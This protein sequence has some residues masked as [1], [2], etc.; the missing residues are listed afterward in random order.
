[1]RLVE[2][3]W[4]MRRNNGTV[5]AAG[6]NVLIS[7][8]VGAQSTKPQLAPQGAYAGIGLDAPCEAAL[9]QEFDCHAV[10]GE[11]S[12]QG[13][14]GSIGDKSSTD[15]V[16]ALFCAKA[17]DTLRR[18][19]L[20][21]CRRTPDLV[22]GCAVIALVDTIMTGWNEACQK[23]KETGQYCNSEFPL[24]S[25]F[26]VSFKKASG[27]RPLTSSL[28]ITESFQDVEE[29]KDMPR[30]ELCSYCYGARLR[31]MQNSPYSA[32][33][34][35]YAEISEIRWQLTFTQ[36]CGINSPTDILSDPASI[37]YPDSE[38]CEAVQKYKVREGDTCD[39]VAQSQSVSSATLYYI[40]PRLINCMA[41]EPGLE[42]CLPDQCETT[43]TI[44]SKE[45]RCVAIASRH[46]TSWTDII[47]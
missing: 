5:W 42:L 47:E 46:G 17:L 20:A 10:V 28:A 32:Y 15:S 38:R 27:T 19:V 2:L 7:A 36:E 6:V 30:K 29:L 16:C 37:Q 4:K 41:P 26:A 44:Q 22:Q 9:Y 25:Q 13:H 18:R 1:M 23:D 12:Y 35:A 34:D 21:V 43:Y 33:D 31:V 39:S 11:L 45:E 14:H 8:L 40:N 3:S 24:D